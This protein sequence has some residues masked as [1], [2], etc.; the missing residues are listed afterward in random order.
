[1]VDRNVKAKLYAQADI[2]AYWVVDVP[3]L[4]IEVR[5]QPGSNGY[6]C[7]DIHREGSIVLS[8]LDGLGGLDVTALFSGIA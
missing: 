2:P 3:G 5:T 1:M 4:A 7:C 8:P 6:A